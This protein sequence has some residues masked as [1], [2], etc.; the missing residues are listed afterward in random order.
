M[1]TRLRRVDPDERDSLRE[2]LAAYLLEFDGQT[3]PYRYFDEYWSDPQRLP[4]FIEVDGKIAGFCLVRRRGLDWT[5]AEFT[6]IPES[7]RNGIGRLAVA[8]IRESAVTAG[9]SYVEAT[10]DRE[11]AQA[12]AFWLACGFRVVEERDVIVTRLDL[13]APVF[14]NDA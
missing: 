9:A 4:F 12:R 6:V 8:A 2:L 3:T 14:R 1:H 5:L 10:V 11:K 13:G 7:R